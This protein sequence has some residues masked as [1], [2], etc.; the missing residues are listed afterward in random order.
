MP[1]FGGQKFDD[2]ALDKLRTLKSRPDVHALL[3]VDGGVA[4]D[5]IGRCAKAGAELF[6]TGTSVF[7]QDDYTTAVRELR[8]AARL[9]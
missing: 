4:V 5:T 3:E 6:V 2:V 7:H 9:Q 8:A 1:G